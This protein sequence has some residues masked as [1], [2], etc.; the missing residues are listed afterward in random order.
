MPASKVSVAWLASLGL[1]ACSSPPQVDKQPPPPAEIT[2]TVTSPA[3]GAELL[4]GERPAIVVSGTVATSDASQGALEA[5]VNGVRV[6]VKDGAFTAEVTPEPGINHIK[7]EG[8]D[9]I[10]DLIG[11]ELDVMW[12]PE[13]LPPLAGQTGFD[14]ANALELRLG[15]RFFDARLLGTALDLSTNPVVAR[16]VAAALELILRHVNLASLLPPGGLQ[17]GQAGASLTIEIP[18]VTPANLIV[19]ARIVDSP[20]P[21]LAVTI[22]LLGVALAMRGNFTLGAT[23]LIVEGGVTAD[24]HAS[25]KL[26]LTTAEDGSIR[27]GVTGVTATVGQLAPGFTGRDGAELGALLAITSSQFHGLIEGLLRTQLI[28]TFT[29]QLPPFLEQLLGATD[30]LLD[31]VNFTLDPGLGSPVTLQL[32][33]HMAALAVIPGATSGHVTVR[34]DLTV[35]TTGTPIHPQSRGAPRLDVSAGEPA[36]TGAGVHLSMRIDF[37]N[38]LLHA[39]WNAGMLEGTLMSGGLAAKV[40]AK[41][42]PVIRPTPASSPCKIDGERCDVQLQLGQIEATLLGQS[43]G[44]N[45]SAGARIE[46]D[47]STVSLKIQMKPDLKVWTTAPGSLTP[48]TIS[49]LIADLVWPM[50]FGAIGDNLKI[51]LPLPDLATLGLADLAPGL[52]DA[53]L[54]L[55]MRQRPSFSAGRMVLGADLTLATPPP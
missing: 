17:I 38:A 39:L 49:T 27:V 12:V 21:A 16:D 4:A 18:S 10:T 19:D 36:S 22:D 3:P 1:A 34:E 7:V 28:P 15:Q 46:V 31:N 11:R 50:L 45:A 47:G 32:D 30:Q 9:G 29:E 6:Q 25:A 8:G 52:A 23:T 43:F 20:E 51:Q 42:P 26:T 40:S 55:Q 33:G 14:I 44:L 13:Y 41:L 53:E 5:W 2:L 54:L 48:D 37:L 35:R 24:L